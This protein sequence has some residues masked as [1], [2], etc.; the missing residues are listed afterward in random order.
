MLRR[1]AILGGIALL[2]AGVLLITLWV[3]RA[4]PTLS[5]SVVDSEGKPVVGAEVIAHA[6]WAPAEVIG[7]ASTDPAGRFELHGL[8]PGRCSLLVH[9]PGYGVSMPKCDVPSDGTVITL[10]TGATIAGKI[11][12]APG[13]EKTPICEVRVDALDQLDTRGKSE[14]SGS[15]VVSASPGNS[16]VHAEGEGHVSPRVKLE[17]APGERRE[18]LLK[19]EKAGHVELKVKSDAGERPGFVF[20]ESS[21]PDGS[22]LEGF[23]N[24]DHSCSFDHVLPG[25]VRIV[26]CIPGEGVAILEN[27]EVK[28]GETAEVEI[29]LPETQGIFGIVHRGVEPVKDARVVATWTGGSAD[30]RTSSGGFYYLRGM[31]AGACE[32]VLEGPGSTVP[33]RRVVEVP[34][35]GALLRNLFLDRG[36]VSGTVTS[37]GRPVSDVRI[38]FEGEGMSSSLSDPTDPAG[39]WDV[40]VTAPG[41]YVLR[42]YRGEEAVGRPHTLVLESPRDDVRV[43]IGLKKG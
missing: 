19:V 6:L 20:L 14:P 13:S 12:P 43:D 2:G 38:H 23:L 24:E 11:E 42:A 27:V 41:K 16:L 31:P 32:L 8:K 17:L 40:E 18:L 35:R 25:L 21:R 28:A 33:V 7:G 10:P 15:F 37:A 26:A 30:T 9:K 1:P 39:N 36:R 29:P 5:G 22:P 34:D 4:G 3:L